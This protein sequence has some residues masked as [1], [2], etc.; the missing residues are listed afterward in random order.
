MKTLKEF[1]QDMQKEEFRK[2]FEKKAAVIHKENPDYSKLEVISKAAKELGYGL[3][4]ELLEKKTAEAQELSEEELNQVA[5]GS[6]N[7][8]HESKIVYDEYG[9]ESQCSIM[10]WHCLATFMHTETESEEVNCWSNYKC[11]F[12]NN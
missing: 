10:T 3:P 5:G 9:R 2:E 11:L 12:A 4:V 8:M 7:K 6:K 1:D